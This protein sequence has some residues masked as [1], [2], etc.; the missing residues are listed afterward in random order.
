M[1][2]LVDDASRWGEAS[3]LPFDADLRCGHCGGECERKPPGLHCLKPRCGAIGEYWSPKP[4]LRNI[5][6]SKKS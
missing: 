6:W 5:S 1:K 4:G 3:L 2:T